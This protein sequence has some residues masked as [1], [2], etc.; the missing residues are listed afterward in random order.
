MS[1]SFSNINENEQMHP[2]NPFITK[3]KTFLYFFFFNIIHDSTLEMFHILCFYNIKDVV[4][5][6]QVKIYKEKGL[7]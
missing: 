6:L 7:S 3:I 4:M 1:L 5:F 2:L